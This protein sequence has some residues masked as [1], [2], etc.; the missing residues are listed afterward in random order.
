M[1]TQLK[2]GVLE[3]VVL[4]KIAEHDRYGYDIYQD[5]SQNMAISESTIYPILRK[6]TKEGLCETYLRESSEGPPRK[7][8]RVS[9]KGNGRL[10]ELKKDWEKFQRVVNKMIRS[11]RY[12]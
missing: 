7:Y 4:S 12:E 9:K 3:M 6:L 2:K 8:F 5:I 10:S 11:D 1:S